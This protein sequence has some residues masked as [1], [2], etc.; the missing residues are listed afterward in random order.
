MIYYW[1]VQFLNKIVV[2]HAHNAKE[3]DSLMKAWI[4]KQGIPETTPYKKGDSYCAKKDTPED[5]VD[6]EKEHLKQ[7]LD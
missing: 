7:W 5:I 4:K 6:K 2:V 1:K 3:C